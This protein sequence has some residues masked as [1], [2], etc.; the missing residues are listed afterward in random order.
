MQGTAFM[1]APTNIYLDYIRNTCVEEVATATRLQ[2]GSYSGV[3]LDIF[4][5]YVL[6]RQSTFQFPTFSFLLRF[7]L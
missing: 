1:C 5:S 2:Q 3:H 7:L 4:H 6:F